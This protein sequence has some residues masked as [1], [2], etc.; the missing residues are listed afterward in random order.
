MTNMPNDDA[1]YED[2]KSLKSLIKTLE[3]Y[4]EIRFDMENI[5]NAITALNACNFNTVKKEP[6]F[7][8]AQ[9]KE[10]ETLT[11]DLKEIAHEYE[12]NKNYAQ[13]IRDTLW[14]IRD[15]LGTYS[16]LTLINHNLVNSLEMLFSGAII[17]YAKAFSESQRRTSLD[18]GK[19]FKAHPDCYLFHEKVIDLRNKHYAHS[20]Y[21]YNRHTLKYILSQ[22]GKDIDFS[23]NT[24]VQHEIWTN[25]DYI[26]FYR[27]I[28]IVKRFLQIEIKNKINVIKNKLSPTQKEFLLSQTQT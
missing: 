5:I 3:S 1:F 11:E 16:T 21:N 15:E 17:S 6:I 26:D 28:N 24:H 20:Q 10:L 4:I 12:E 8:D 22:D 2:N 9:M 23:V 14:E 19:I 13:S 7:T 18:S 25:F 27:T